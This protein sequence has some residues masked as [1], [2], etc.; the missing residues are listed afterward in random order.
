MSKGTL[1]GN[2]RY[3][4]GQFKPG[5]TFGTLKRK[6]IKQELVEAIARAEIKQEKGF[7]DRLLE[8]A[9]FNPKVM[10]AILDRFLPP[11]L[12]ANITHEEIE[13]MNIKIEIVEPKK[14]KEIKK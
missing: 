1:D 6:R 3:R 13:K 14:P 11:E 8:M 4:K 10:I 9:Y 2:K 5:N 7:L 12:R